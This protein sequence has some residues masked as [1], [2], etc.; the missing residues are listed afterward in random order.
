M[1]RHLSPDDGCRW[2]S[3]RKLAALEVVTNSDGSRLDHLRRPAERQAY[4]ALS[5]IGLGPEELPT[6]QPKDG[7]PAQ[8]M[9]HGAARVILWQCQSFHADAAGR[10]RERQGGNGGKLIPQQGS[11]RID[12]PAEL[13]ETSVVGILGKAL[14]QEHYERRYAEKNICVDPMQRQLLVRREREGPD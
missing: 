10:I 2:S 12:E 8:F 3:P 14:H 7:P 13:A 11:I 5:G 6:G 9:P 1:R 4:R